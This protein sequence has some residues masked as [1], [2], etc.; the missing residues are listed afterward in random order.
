MAKEGT[1]ISIDDEERNG[2]LGAVEEEER[3][4]EENVAVEEGEEDDADEEEEEEEEE[5]YTFRFQNEMSPLDFV[6]NNDSGVQ[7]YQ[8]FE[9]LE[10]EALADRKR[11]AN[12]QCHR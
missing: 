11:K 5:E 1:D 8:Q 7:R 10:Y 9:R 12:E 3:D 6:G 2:T 4:E